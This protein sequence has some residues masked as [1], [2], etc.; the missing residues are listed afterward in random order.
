MLSTAHFLRLSLLSLIRVYLQHCW[1]A[2]S[3]HK[4]A[5]AG[6]EQEREGSKRIQAQ[7]RWVR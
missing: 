3:G 4:D 1:Q 2:A 7:Q 6:C 5:R